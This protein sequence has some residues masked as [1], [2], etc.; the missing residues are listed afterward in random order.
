MNDVLTLMEII[1]EVII[2]LMIFTRMGGGLLI[3]LRNLI[4]EIAKGGRG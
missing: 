2:I 4:Y 1:I 3:E